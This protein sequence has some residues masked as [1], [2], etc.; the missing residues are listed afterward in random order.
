V[1]TPW[2]PFGS[3]FDAARI[4]ISAGLVI[5]VTRS[6]DKC[7]SPLWPRAYPS[8]INKH[9]LV[10]CPLLDLMFSQSRPWDTNNFWHAM[11]Q[12]TRGIAEADRLPGLLLG[13]ERL[14]G[15]S[16]YQDVPSEYQDLPAGNI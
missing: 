10:N 6:R 12:Q 4:A 8:L 11:S 7:G 13:G 5:G 15:P 16:E 3:A 2:L 14:D 9:R 1:R